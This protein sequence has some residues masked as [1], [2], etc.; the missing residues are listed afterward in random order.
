M[1]RKL[2]LL[3]LLPRTR[4]KRLLNQWQHPLSLMLRAREHAANVLSGELMQSRNRVPQYRL[5]HTGKINW[6]R[7]LTQC[8][9]LIDVYFH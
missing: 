4:A 5:R 1:P 8:T 9:F 6:N 2:E 7:L 3:S